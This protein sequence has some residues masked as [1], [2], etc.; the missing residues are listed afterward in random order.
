MG[1]VVLDLFVIEYFAGF[2]KCFFQRSRGLSFVHL[3][4]AQNVSKN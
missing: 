1:E 2:G 4:R 3:V